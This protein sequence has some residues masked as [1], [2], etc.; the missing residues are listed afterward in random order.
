MERATRQHISHKK[1]DS[2][3]ADS[4]SEN[5]R[6]SAAGGGGVNKLMSYA[7]AGLAASLTP[8]PVPQRQVRYQ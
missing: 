7:V 4:G 6:T 3:G 2:P 8:P 5:R 1:W